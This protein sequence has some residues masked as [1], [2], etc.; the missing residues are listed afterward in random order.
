[1]MQ[2]LAVFDCGT[3]GTHA[4]PTRV[5]LGVDGKS[6][7]VQ[8]FTATGTRGTRGTL[9]SNN[10]ASVLQSRPSLGVAPGRQ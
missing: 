7:T 8:S 4:E 10:A 3:A 5:S 1:M 9:Q 6:I 2:L